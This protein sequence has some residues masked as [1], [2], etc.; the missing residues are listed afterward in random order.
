MLGR[1]ILRTG[2]PAMALADAGRRDNAGLGILCIV[3]GM[4]CISVQDMMI[5][6]LSGDYPLHEIVFARSA[7]AIVVSFALVWMEG[8]LRILRTDQ[9]L[10]HLFRALMVVAANMLFFVGLAALPIAQATGIFFIA[11]LL[12]TLLSIP[13]LGERV[14]PRRLAAAAVGFVG[15]A[16]MMRPW[17]AGTSVAAFFPLGAALAY[18][19]FQIMTRRL[20]LKAKASAMA[21]YIQSTMIVVSLGFFAV[22]GDGRFA[23]GS[24]DP[25]INFLLRAWR[26]PEGGD[27]WLFIGIGLLSSLIAY[28]LAQAYRVADAAVISPFEYLALPLA[29]M[30]GWA[31]FGEL[32]DLWIAA[33][34]VVIISAGLYTFLRERVQ[35]RRV[36]AKRPFR[37]W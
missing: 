11:P 16:L 26:W 27:W 28:L 23:A 3:I 12:I 4:S 36:A 2:L 5:K 22:A 10:A 34:I 9:P 24:E 17:S 29:V 18:A 33:G 30:W 19:L 7:L 1:H 21:V 35:G 14:G 20:G 8:G 6:R 25:S 37:R 31:V 15:V 32:P 13:L